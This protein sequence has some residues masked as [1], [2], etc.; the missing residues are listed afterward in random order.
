MVVSLQGYPARKLQLQHVSHK[1]KLTPLDGLSFAAK[2]RD[3]GHETPPYVTT[4]LFPYPPVDWFLGSSF[5]LPA[6]EQS[7]PFV[8]AVSRV[9]SQ[10]WRSYERQDKDPGSPIRSGMTTI[11]DKDEE[12]TLDPRLTMSR[13]TAGRKA[14]KAKTLDPRSESGTSVDGC[15]AGR[16]AKKQRLWIPDQ[17]GDDRQK[18]K[19]TEIPSLTGSSIRAC[20]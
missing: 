18:T 9:L 5:R 10:G 8:A 15:T 2:Q 1:G 11:K 20:P 12:T 16:R 4:C 6:G 14:K 19:T 7:F 17:V 13:M 3:R